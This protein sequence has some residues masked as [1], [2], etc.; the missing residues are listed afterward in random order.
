MDQ[1]GCA[2]EVLVADGQ[3]VKVRGDP[4]GR[5]NQGYICPKG[6]ASPKRLT[7]PDRLTR[8]LRRE[9]SGW[10]TISWTEALYQIAEAFNR[11]KEVHGARAISFCQGMPKGLE[12]LSLIRLANTFGSP[13]VVGSQNVC[14]MPRE[15]SGVHTC[16]FYPVVN[17][18]LPTDCVL[19]W[20]SNPTSTNEEGVI[21][22]QLLAQLKGGARLV[23]VDPQRTQMAQRAE[24]WLQLR[25]GSEAALALSLLAVIIEEN[26]YDREF[27]ARWTHGFDELA[28]HAAR[29]R[30]EET[31]VWTWLE[32]E[33]VRRAARLYAQAPAAALH[34][35]NGVE[36]GVSNFDTCRALVCLMALTGNLDAPGGN[37]DAGQPPVLSLREF[38]RADLMPAK[39][40]EA[41]FAGYGLLPRFMT[42]PPPMWRRAI[43][44]GEPYPVRA[45]YVQTSNPVISYSDSRQTAAALKS[46]DFLVVSEITM[47]PTAALADI[48]LPAA[49]QFEFNDIGHYGLG[50]GFILARPQLVEPPKECWPDLKIH[51]ELAKALGLGDL[52]WEDYQE[53]L[54]ALLAPSGLDYAQFAEQ[55]VLAV[56]PRFR[57]Y[58]TQ[59]FKTPTGKVEL[60]LSKAAKMGF[61]ALPQWKGLPFGPSEENPDY[62]LILNSAKCKFYLGSSD[63]GLADLRRLR[64]RPIVRVHPQTATALGLADGQPVRIETEHGSIVQY[65]ELWDGVDPRVVTAE[66]GWWYPEKGAAWDEA[67]LN[68]LTKS[69][70]LSQAFGTPNLRAIPCRLAPV[71]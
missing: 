42:V 60:A 55:G 19:L 26:L 17:Y 12:H 38:A 48:V 57:K 22:T 67:N 63:R 23:V 32:P 4:S 1:G 69:E 6:L 61:P 53:L 13:N 33:A 50:H 62:P 46:L 54:D 41:I 39:H 27:T 37:I 71:S 25:P 35:G 51:N 9:G 34:W 14:H 40:K 58:E 52:W 8:P 43:L 68:L 20:G 30:P 56:E 45:A 70:P 66:P 10:R 11:I 5:L 49:T 36:H 3:I 2:L 29:F 28:G 21:H 47:T 24:V 15:I 65:A 44:E 7:N 16:G 31:G 64:P 59:G 18:D